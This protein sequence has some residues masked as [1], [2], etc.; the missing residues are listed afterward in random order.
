MKTKDISRSIINHIDKFGKLPVAIHKMPLDVLCLVE[1][2]LYARCIRLMDNLEQAIN[3]HQYVHVLD[4]EEEI[5][6]F[7]SAANIVTNI[8]FSIGEDT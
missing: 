1:H 4:I 7:D 3:N 2:D 8:V 5:D 6:Q